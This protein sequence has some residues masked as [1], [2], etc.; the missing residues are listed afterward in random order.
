MSGSG[1]PKPL[2]GRGVKQRSRAQQ[3]AQETQQEEEEVPQEEEHVPVVEPVVA[4]G[5]K[6]EVAAGG[7]KFIFIFLSNFKSLSDI[8]HYIILSYYTIYC[9]KLIKNCS[10]LFKSFDVYLFIC[11]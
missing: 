9:Q 8:I 5:E 2:G 1:P 7:G 10:F 11:F 3:Q 4:E 6:K